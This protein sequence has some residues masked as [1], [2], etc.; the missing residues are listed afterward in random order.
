VHEGHFDEARTDM[1]IWHDQVTEPIGGGWPVIEVGTNAPV[2]VMAVV[3]HIRAQ[4][5]EAAS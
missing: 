2:D 3:D 1:E 5:G 4:A